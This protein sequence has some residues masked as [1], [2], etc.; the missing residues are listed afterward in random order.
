MEKKSKIKKQKIKTPRIFGVKVHNVT[1]SQALK[2]AERFLHDSRQHYIVTPNPEIVLHALKNPRY[3]MI[4][5]KADL[6]VPDGIGLLWASKKIYGE[7]V[8]R[9]RIA[10]VDFMIEFLKNLTRKFSPWESAKPKRILLLGGKSNVAYQT[11]EV[12]R[13]KFPRIYFHTIQNHENKHVTFLI[14]E[15]I[16][17]D[18]IF[19][20]LG[21]PKQEIWIHKNLSKFSTVKLAM[22]VGGAFDMIA[23][24]IPRAPRMLQKFHIEWLW[25]FILQPWRFQRIF[26][27]T[28]VFP[29]LVL[30]SIYPHLAFFRVCYNKTRKKSKTKI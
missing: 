25:R 24:R 1:L 15:I 30:A 2:Q 5:N 27:A 16:Q 8:L 12:F 11:A 29:L 6:S 10:G 14:N 22:G 4:L 9:E 23:G 26:T 3:R 21:A 18:C 13:K 7:N 28:V 20:A 19:V 17:P